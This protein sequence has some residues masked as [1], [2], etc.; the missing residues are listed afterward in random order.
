MVVKPKRIKYNTKGAAQ[1]LRSAFIIPAGN[2]VTTLTWSR[3][4]DNIILA[5]QG[6]RWQKLPG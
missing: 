6:K 5:P 1:K 3:W 4:H 2:C